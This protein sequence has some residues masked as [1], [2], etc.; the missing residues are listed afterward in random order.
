[1]VAWLKR[2][3]DLLNCYF[4]F[5]SDNRRRKV[6][7]VLLDACD[8]IASEW[9]FEFL[10]LQAY[11]DDK[12]ARLLYARNGYKIISIDPWWLSKW[13]GKRRRVILAKNASPCKI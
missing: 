10:V 11:E 12:A 4:V 3:M 9:G 1:M 8:L 5:S 6:A 13:F 7:T 2:A